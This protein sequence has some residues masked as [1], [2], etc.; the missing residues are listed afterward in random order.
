LRKSSRDKPKPS[1]LGEG[2]LCWWPS[3][4]NRQTE[5]EDIVRLGR[6]YDFQQKVNLHQ[7]KAICVASRGSLK[8]PQHPR[9]FVYIHRDGY[10]ACTCPDFTSRG[11]VCKHLRALRLVLEN[12]VARRLIG[13][14][15]YPPTSEA[16]RNVRS[17]ATVGPPGAHA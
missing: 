13:P 8:D 2:N 3:D 11:A 17:F 1:S 7:Y 10:A 9:Y 5:A 15:Y 4:L 16:A 6:I 12:W 14:F